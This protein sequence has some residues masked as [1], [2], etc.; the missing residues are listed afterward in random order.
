MAKKNYCFSIE[1][2]DYNDFSELVKNSLTSV[3]REI[4]LF[5]RNE[6]E[7]SKEV[8]SNE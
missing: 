1:E 4:N 7:K 8:K 6:V 3:S 5:M 2:K